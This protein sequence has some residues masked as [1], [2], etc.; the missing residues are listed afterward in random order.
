MVNKIVLRN[1]VQFSSTMEKTLA[2]GLKNLSTTTRI[3]ASKLLD[4]AVSDLLA[5]YE[6][7]TT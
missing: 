4:E 2:A 7:K 6:K 1:R 5:K 3:P